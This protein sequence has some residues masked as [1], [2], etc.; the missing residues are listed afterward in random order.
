MP[1]PLLTTWEKRLS[2][3]ANRRCCSLAP[4]IQSSDLLRDS[5]TGN[6]QMRHLTCRASTASVVNECL[7]QL[8]VPRLST[9]QHRVHPLAMPHPTSHESAVQY[10]KQPPLTRAYKF[11]T[12][13]GGP[14]CPVKVPVEQQ[15]V[16]TCSTLSTSGVMLAGTSNSMSMEASLVIS[17]RCVDSADSVLLVR[18]TAL[19]PS[20][21]TAGAGAA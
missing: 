19:S 2:Q 15:A 6:R 5:L 7:Q 11:S 13:P 21:V 3:A 4:N 17:R 20:L 8:P 9:C 12:K 16:L 14:I 10:S 1:R 18:A